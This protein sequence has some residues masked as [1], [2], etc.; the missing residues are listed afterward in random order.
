MDTPTR[1][2]SNKE[3]T[4]EWRDY[5]CIHCGNCITGLPSV[6]KINRRPWIQLDNATPEEIKKQVSNCP[7][8]AL[9][10]ATTTRKEQESNS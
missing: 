9:K 10:D 3:I 1:T 5:L 7:S 2:Y 8:G 6:F 4:I